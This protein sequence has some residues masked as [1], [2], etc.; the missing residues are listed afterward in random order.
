MSLDWKKTVDVISFS[1]FT[2]GV[3]I[4]DHAI[5]LNQNQIADCMNAILLKRGFKRYPGTVNLTAKDACSD[6]FRGMFHS[7]NIT[8]TNFLYEVHGGKVYSVDKTTGSLTELYDMTG[9]GEAWGSV[10]HGKLFLCN[11]SK[12]IK[13]EGNTAYQVGITPP[14]GVTATG[15]NTGGTLP[16]GVYK[17][18]AGYARRSS[19][20]DVLYSK[21][22]S[23]T[24]VTISGSNVGKIVIANFANSSDLQVGNKVIW[25]TLAN[26]V[27]YYL[28]DS[29][30]DNSTTTWEITSTST[31]NNAITYDAYAMN[32]DLPGAFTF[33]FIM[34]KRIF[35]VIDN[36]VYYSLKGAT[37]YDLERFP[38]KNNITY[39][40]RITGL[41]SCG[42]HLCINTAENGVIIQPNADITAKFEHIEQITSFRY[43]RTVANWN[44]NK[45]GMTSDRI[46]L[47]RSDTLKFDPFDYGINIK[48]VLQRV[49]VNDDSN[50]RPCGVVFR[51]ENRNEYQ[52]SIMDSLVND[53]NNNRTYVLNLS[54]TIFQDIDNYNTPWEII[55]RGFNYAVVDTANTLFMAQSFEGSSTIYKELA[56]HSTEI[57]IYKDAGTYLDTATDMLM[58]IKTRTVTKNMFTKMI[59]ENIRALFKSSKISNLLITVEDDPAKLITQDTTA[60]AFG[61]TL[62][63]DFNWADTDGD[64]PI[65]S[66][67]NLMQFEYKGDMGVFGYSW[68]LKFS[69]TSDDIDLIIAQFD[70][71]VT[72]ETGRGI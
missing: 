46:G 37:E 48:P 10:S 5:S 16:N 66:A 6:Y 28:F 21:G 26:G 60:S 43:I 55:G 72:N 61:Q 7:S 23:I 58:Y 41:F 4:N 47:F 57:G 69:Q 30:G 44:G 38:T 31:Y 64:E 29:T 39:P 24:D 14:T 54:R 17:I 40:Y 67:E 42:G 52:L 11:G 1:D 56:Q 19:G 8:G 3:N 15:S 18:F 49:W 13:I 53:K 63:D 22:Q 62:W 51:R 33:L 27:T 12:V 36:I 32:N 59:I 68:S 71:K 65:W 9:Q 25:M 20:T 70:V 45:I 50:H 35:G 2:G 34:D